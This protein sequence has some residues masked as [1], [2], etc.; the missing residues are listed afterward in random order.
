[1]RLWRATWL[2]TW[3]TSP[4]SLRGW[5]RS[6]SWSARSA[7]T[8]HHHFAD[9]LHLFVALEAWKLS[10]YWL[11]VPTQSPRAGSGVERI[12]PLR[13]LAGCRTRRLNQ[14]LSIQP[15]FV[16]CVVLL[17]MAPF[18]RCVIFV[19]FLFCH[20]VVLVRLSVPVQVFD[21]SCAASA[22]RRNGLHRR[23]QHRRVEIGLLQLTLWCTVLP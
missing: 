20:L 13:F 5:P 12:D 14:A 16:E 11:V 2:R 21:W 8:S 7:C 10:S 9:D 6:V 1:M 17:T 19:L 18:L 22:N 4:H 23:L 15:R 3:P